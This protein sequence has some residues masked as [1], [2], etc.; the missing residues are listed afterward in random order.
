MKRVPTGQEFLASF[1]KALAER[2]LSRAV[3]CR[4]AAAVTLNDR[5]APEWTNALLNIVVSI[6]KNLGYDVYPSRYVLNATKRN[7]RYGEDGD[8]GEWLYDACWTRYPSNAGLVRHLR[9]VQSGEAKRHERYLDLACESEWGGKTRDLHVQAV[10]DDFAKLVECRAPLKVM[11]FG[12]HKSGEGSF[13]D[14][15]GML[16]ALAQSDSVRA[17]YVL[18]GWEDSA[19]WAERMERRASTVINV[20]QPDRA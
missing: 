5:G 19:R 1:D 14:L 20:S 9:A 10:V 16:G 8:V 7:S 11:I 3:K 2:T 13:E 15:V 17:D 12:Y 4:E 18:L 6:G